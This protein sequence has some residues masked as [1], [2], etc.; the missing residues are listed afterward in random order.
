MQKNEFYEESARE[1]KLKRKKNGI[2]LSHKEWD[3]DNLSF[4]DTCLS[5]IDLSSIIKDSC[6]LTNMPSSQIRL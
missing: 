3:S 5:G 1:I 2:F 4:V 6:E